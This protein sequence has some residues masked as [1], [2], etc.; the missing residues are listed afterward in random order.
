[1]SRLR[2]LVTDMGS[3]KQLPLFAA[4]LQHL[5]WLN[6]GFTN[7]RADVLACVAGLPSLKH[8]GVCCSSMS[9]APPLVHPTSL[10]L[11]VTSQSGHG[12][13]WLCGATQLQRLRMRRPSKGATMIPDSISKLVNL[14]ELQ[15]LGFEISLPKCLTALTGVKALA[16]TPGFEAGPL[17]LGV[18]W[19]MQSLEQL[20]IWDNHMAA[21]PEAV[22]YLTNL[23]QL[24]LIGH[25]WASL[26]NA[27]SSLVGLGDIQLLAPQLQQLPEGLTA[28]TAL[29]AFQAVG[30][31]LQAQ[32]PAVRGLLE[33]RRAQGCLLQLA[34]E[35]GGV[36][37]GPGV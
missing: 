18:V 1:M 6:C 12:W 3:M 9:A 37:G 5:V 36:S 24:R 27:I 14:R 22:T 7:I 2:M 23:W 4:S 35:K 34:P 13:E 10:D 33:A 25:A 26:P 16:L 20:Q 19:R 31:R 28:L 17:C 32:S 8:L 11:S 30:V 29:T 15:L 21:V